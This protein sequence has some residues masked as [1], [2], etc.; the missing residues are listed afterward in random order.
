MPQAQG[1]NHIP[2]GRMWGGSREL[3]SQS[4]WYVPEHIPAMDYSGE[5]LDSK[6]MAPEEVA[7]VCPASDFWAKLHS[8]EQRVTSSQ[9]G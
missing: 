3:G 9:P 6:S 7:L 8:G 5:R 2:K 1:S 4:F